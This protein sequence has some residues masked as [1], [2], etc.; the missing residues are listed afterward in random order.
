MTGGSKIMYIEVVEFKE[1]RYI[2]NRE[3]EVTD[4]EEG[5]KLT[6]AKGEEQ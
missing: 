5:R 1:V 2:L 6:L 4:Y 3:A